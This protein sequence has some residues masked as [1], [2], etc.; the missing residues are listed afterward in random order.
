M[1]E[2]NFASIGDQ[3]TKIEKYK[4]LLHELLNGCQIAQ[5]KQFIDHLLAE[6]VPLVVSRQVLQEL[7]SSLQACLATELKAG[8]PGA[9]VLG[10]N[11]LKEVGGYVLDMSVARAVSFEEQISSIRETLSTVYEKDE[12]WS[13]AAKMLAGIPLDSGIRVLDDNYKVEKYIK[14]A[15]LYL[16]DEENVS[17]EAFINRASLL[18]GEETD[19]ELKLK[20][21]VCYARILDAKRKFLEAATRFYQLS[22]LQT[23][24]FGG[25]KEVS[26]SELM[27]VLKHAV[28]AAILAPAGPQRSRLLKTL[29]K[30]ERS[31]KLPTYKLLEKIF[32]DRSPA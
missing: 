25:G 19:A 8:A 17:A 11:D 20:H 4:A 31:A 18:I 22:Q 12:D 2:V 3:K 24:Q 14:I 6:E 29:Y 13:S 9:A 10:S 23:R 30:D 16:Q 15:M 21:K 7:A 5:L 28:R 26:E 1:L 32:M 27:L